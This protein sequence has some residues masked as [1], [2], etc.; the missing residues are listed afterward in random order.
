MTI[1]NTILSQ[2]GGNGFI[3]MTG[4]K[5]FLD[6]GRS[7]RMTL[8]QNNSGANR[9]TIT[10]NKMDTYD[11]EFYRMTMNRKTGN[12]KI[13]KKASLEGIYNDMLQDVFTQITGLCTRL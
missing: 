1:A 9:L 5:N 8:T 13:T 3:A 11:L 10:L 2:L 7:L 6:D 12:C 4:S